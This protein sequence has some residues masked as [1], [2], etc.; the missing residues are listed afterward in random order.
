MIYSFAA[1]R[2][3]MS[4]LFIKKGTFNHC[5]RS[6]ASLVEHHG[7]YVFFCDIYTHTFSHT[8]TH[9]RTHTYTN[10]YTNTC[11]FSCACACVSL[12]FLLCGAVGGGVGW[13]GVWCG[14]VW[15]GK[16]WV[17]SNVFPQDWS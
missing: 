2:F 3:V 14:V 15:C 4:T 16:K 9:T 6:K 5:E 10:T 13:G 17:I 7:M 12:F 11:T 1:V 8:R